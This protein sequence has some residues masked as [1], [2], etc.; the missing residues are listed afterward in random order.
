MNNIRMIVSYDGTDYSGFQSQP[1]GNTIQDVLEAAIRSLTKEDGLRII[2]SGRTDAGVHAQGQ[3]FNFHTESRIP[4]ERWTLAINARLPDD[5]VVLQADLMPPEFHARHSAL[6]KTY[7]YV[8][9][10]S[11]FPDVFQRR[12]AL[13]HYAPLDVQAMREGL[14]ELVGEHDFTSFASPQSTQP[15]HVRTI[16]NIALLESPNKLE[17]YVTGSGFLYNMVRIIAGTAVWIGEGKLSPGDIPAILAAR[18]RTLAGP[19]A[20]AHGLTLWQVEYPEF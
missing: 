10:T 14:Q 3:V 19:T 4:V 13:H 9:D 5:I 1:S 8:I 16:Y 20:M 11:Q 17:L 6:S 18:D 12:Y 7:R 15:S 2:G